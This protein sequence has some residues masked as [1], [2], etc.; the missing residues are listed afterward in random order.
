V[1]PVERSGFQPVARTESV[2]FVPFDPSSSPPVAASGW[3]AWAEEYAR[4]GQTSPGYSLG[5]ELLHALV[6]ELAPKPASQTSWVLDFNCGAGDDLERFL[7][8]GWNAVGCDGSS[9]MLRRAA[10]RSATELS[11]GRLELWMG[12][13]GD[14]QAGCFRRQFD[15]VFSTTGGFAYLDDQAFVRVHRALAAMLRPGG[16]MILAHLT[17]FCFAETLYYLA[18]FSPRAAVRRWRR[19][20]PIEIRGERMR[21]RLRSPS[22]LRR[23]LRGTVRIDAIVPLLVVTPP[24]QTG[25]VPTGATLAA[26]HKVERAVGHIEA[27]AAVAD[28]AVCI[29]RACG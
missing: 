1:A 4:L 28:Q 24:F 20:L 19:E 7:A 8:R 21:M 3:D 14:T 16:L 26:L 18:H 29:A 11:E 10:E 22:R 12:E 23:L 13:A 15:L 25:F 9:G 6:D 27:L 2:N 5:K 17:P